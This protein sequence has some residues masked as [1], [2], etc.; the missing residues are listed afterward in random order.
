VADLWQRQVDQL[1]ERVRSWAGNP[2]EVLEL[3]IDELSDAAARDDRLVADLRRDAISL[4]GVDIRALLRPAIRGGPVSSAREDARIH[5]AR[6]RE[7]LEAATFSLE[8][9]LLSAA[10]S[11]AVIAGINAKD[12][13]CLRLTG[14]TRKLDARAE[15][16][17]G[18]RAGGPAGASLAPTLSRLLGLKK[19]SRYQSAS[20]AAADA[21]KAIAWATR[22]VHG[23]EDVVSSR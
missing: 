18:L 23:A 21:D 15:A 9:S 12:A 7:F 13:I 22:L 11:D 3:T 1:V 10:T 8:L 20:V 16:V 4:A 6:A 14:V 19:K 5:L 17:A 2:C